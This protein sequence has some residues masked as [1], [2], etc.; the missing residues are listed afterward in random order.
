[1]INVSI[2]ENDQRHRLAL[3]KLLEQSDL[4]TL[5]GSYQS[6]EDALPCLLAQRP[7]IVIVDVSLPAMSG[8]SMIKTLTNKLPNTRF[9]VYTSY[10]NDDSI[11]EALKAGASGYLLWGSTEDDIRWA[12]KELFMGGAPLSP[13]VARRIVDSFKHSET[14]INGYHL[15]GREFEILKFMMVGLLNKEIAS[16]LSISNNTVKNHLK[17]VYK[18]MGA[19]NKIEVINKCQH[20]LL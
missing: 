15:T 3:V 10:Y 9:L 17:K 5:K 8:I 11:F 14:N 12:I 4:F 2:V 20:L 18:K 7:D 1:M 13:L 6:A 16:K 19:Q